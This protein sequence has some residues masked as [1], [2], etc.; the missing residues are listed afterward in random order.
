MLE[1]TLA[2]LRE[3]S[4]R[5]EQE[6]LQ[7]AWLPMLS[8]PQ[9]SP[10]PREPLIHSVSCSTREFCTP[11]NTSMENLG[12]IERFSVEMTQYLDRLEG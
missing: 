7:L 8:L 2:F 1:Q 9:G 5:T 3:L 10:S 6:Y 11:T 4:R 12:D